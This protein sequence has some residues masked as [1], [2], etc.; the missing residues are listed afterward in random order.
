[1]ARVSLVVGL[2]AAGLLAALLLGGGGAGGAALPSAATERPAGTLAF[3][4]RSSRLGS[5]DVA[6]GHTTERRVRALAA[7]GPELHVTGGHVFFAGVRKGGTVVYSTPVSLDQAPTR[8]GAAHVFVPSATKGRVWLAGVDCNRVR[9]VGVREASADGH[10]T[11]ASRRRVPGTWIAG[12]VEGGL[13]V[14]RG[15]TVSLWDPRGG[16]SRRLALKGVF[17]AYGSRL[18]GCRD[19]SCRKLV[20][21]DVATGAKVA[22][23]LPDGYRPDFAA[24]FSPDGSLVATPAFANRRYSVAL[25]D[26]RNGSS[27]IVPRSRTGGHYPDLSWSASSGWLFFRAGGGRLMAYRPDAPRAVTLPFR[28]PPG[29]IGFA[30]G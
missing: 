21:L 2:A 25:V 8:I 26:T 20:I 4:M 28:M 23:R 29:A 14:Q 19:S 13:V 30:A 18:L 3:V 24:E 10:V 11:F 1:M 6:T 9:M 12:A 15:R 27:T 5:I 7:C 22:V 16:E 17:A